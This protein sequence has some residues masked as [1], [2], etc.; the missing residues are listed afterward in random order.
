MD[1]PV[2]HDMS[3]QVKLERAKPWVAP[4]KGCQTRGNH[5]VVVQFGSSQI[6]PRSIVEDDRSIAVSKIG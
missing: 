6:R 3:L 1:V 4:V 5:Q 2:V